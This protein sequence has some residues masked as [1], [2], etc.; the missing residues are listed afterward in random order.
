MFM[1]VHI[2]VTQEI[3]TGIIPLEAVCINP[4]RKGLTLVENPVWDLLL[5]T[6]QS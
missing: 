1:F 3:T 5:E 2:E 6:N 4:Y